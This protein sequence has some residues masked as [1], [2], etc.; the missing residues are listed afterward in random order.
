MSND[1]SNEVDM[2]PFIR[3]HLGD[4]FGHFFKPKSVYLKESSS[5]RS[6][7]MVLELSDEE[8]DRFSE[9]IES[10]KDSNIAKL[11]IYY[12]SLCSA[13]L[14]LHGAFEVDN[15]HYDIQQVLLELI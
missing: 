6:V 2:A 7:S 5:I 14:S 10:Y 13:T 3:V 9:I 12:G 8:R 15:V 1:I 4:S 11:K